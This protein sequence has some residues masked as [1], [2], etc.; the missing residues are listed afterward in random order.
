MSSAYHCS[1]CG[2]NWPL[3]PVYAR[4]PECAC[5]TGQIS[6][7]P[8]PDTEADSRRKHAEFEAFWEK[9][10]A[11]RPVREANAIAALDAAIQATP[12]GTPTRR[13]GRREDARHL[14]GGGQFTRGSE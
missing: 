4:C 12:T 11:A 2:T 10:D 5:A 9:W 8:I 3:D 6:V 13:P 1:Q 7:Q 14:G